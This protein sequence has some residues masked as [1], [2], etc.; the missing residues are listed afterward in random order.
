MS[1]WSVTAVVVAAIIVIFSIIL[2]TVIINAVILDSV[3]E[4]MC[5]ILVT[6]NI[7]LVD[8]NGISIIEPNQMKL[9]QRIWRSNIQVGC[10]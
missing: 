1:L 9:L 4:Y 5:C 8:I 6:G 7:N 3:S 10:T 2:V